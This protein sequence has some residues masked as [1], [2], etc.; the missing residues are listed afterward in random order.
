L[1]RHPERHHIVATFNGKNGA[2]P[3]QLALGADGALYGATE[4]G[5]STGGGVIC[6]LTLPR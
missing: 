1:L 3:D 2:Q 6:K 5:G 4:S